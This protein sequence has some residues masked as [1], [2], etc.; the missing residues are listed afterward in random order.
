MSADNIRIKGMEKLNRNL[1]GG[2]VAVLGQQQYDLGVEQGSQEF[3]RKGLRNFA[4][5]LLM[6]NSRMPYQEV[7]KQQFA[8]TP[9]ETYEKILREQNHPD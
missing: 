6:Q 7:L 5:G 1:G 4:R 8:Q 9:P 3:K 2:G